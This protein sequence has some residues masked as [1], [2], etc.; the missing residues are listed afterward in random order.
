MEI[1]L[2]LHVR[3]RRKE[4]D[5]PVAVKNERDTLMMTQVLSW[6]GDFDSKWECVV[7]IAFLGCQVRTNSLRQEGYFIANFINKSQFRHLRCPLE[8]KGHQ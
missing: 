8:Y 6:G 4:E 5:F 2:A 1:G 3:H 7:C